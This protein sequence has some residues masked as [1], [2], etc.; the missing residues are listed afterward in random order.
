MEQSLSRLG[1]MGLEI[2]NE[3][4]TQ[5]VMITEIDDQIDDNANMMDKVQGRI[6]KV[7]KK[8]GC[9]HFSC[10]VC[11]LVTMCILLFFIIYV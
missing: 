1:V 9:S 5:N 4:Q 3:L 7:L 6:A 10:I 2:N 8:S 11:L